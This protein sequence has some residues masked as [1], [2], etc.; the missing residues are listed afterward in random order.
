MASYSMHL[1]MHFELNKQTTDD[2]GKSIGP[3]VT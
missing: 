3:H 2:M 1:V